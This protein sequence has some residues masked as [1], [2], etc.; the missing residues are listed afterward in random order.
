MRGEGGS[1]CDLQEVAGCCWER[2]VIRLCRILLATVDFGLN[3]QIVSTEF[4]KQD[5]ITGGALELILTALQTALG[6]S[7]RILIGRPV[8]TELAG[9]GWQGNVVGI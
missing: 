7:S 5:V 4:E 2:E 3:R 6:E 8:A 9:E 1:H